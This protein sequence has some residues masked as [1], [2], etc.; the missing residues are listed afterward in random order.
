MD[1]KTNDEKLQKSIDDFTDA[2]MK[3]H[4]GGHGEGILLIGI[5][6]GMLFITI[7]IM[8]TTF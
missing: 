8:S 6:M 1:K 3:K 2:I 7:G 5:I 4:Y